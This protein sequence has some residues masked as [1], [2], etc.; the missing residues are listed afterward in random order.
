MLKLFFS[1]LAPESR[2]ENVRAMRALYEAKR[3][4][5]IALKSMAGEMRPGAGLTLEIGLGIT[6]WLVEWCEATERR[7]TAQDEE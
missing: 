4:Q 1:D 3:T 5:L 6:G 2:I 7:L